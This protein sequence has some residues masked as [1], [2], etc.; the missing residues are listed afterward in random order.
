MPSTVSTT[1]A[2]ST[3]KTRTWIAL[4]IVG[5]GALG[6][7]VIS[8]VALAESTDKSETARLIFAA[9]LPLL[10]TWVGAVLAF[11]FTR[12]NLQAGS[13]TALRA[14]RAVGGASPESLVTDIMIPV[15]RIKPVETVANDAAAKQLTLS[16]IYTAMQ[17][18]GQ[19][20]VPVLLDNQSAL[21]V[22]H[23]PDIDKFAQAK[24]IAASALTTETVAD[25]LSEASIA[26]EVTSFVVVGP[27]ATLADARAALGQTV[28]A[29]DVFVTTDGQR[30][31]AAIGWL[32]NSDLARQS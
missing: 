18:S 19:S 13:E 31:S 1:E 8:W 5:L 28:H 25:L 26:P 12:D 22:V 17:A 29:K 9:V 15:N 14:V 27:T 16:K 4:V 30:S 20:R 2:G 21:Y 7:V 32:T 6:I 3:D 10:G 23:E 24:G 11:Y